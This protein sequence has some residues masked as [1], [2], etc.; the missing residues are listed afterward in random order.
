V[1][2]ARMAQAAVPGDVAGSEKGDLVGGWVGIFRI[3]HI[4]RTQ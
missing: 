1:L 3:F 2:L 4:N